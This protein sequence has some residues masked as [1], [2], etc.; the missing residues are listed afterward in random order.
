MVS[1]ATQTEEERET[2]QSSSCVPLGDK[3]V[4]VLN[5]TFRKLTDW[6]KDKCESETMQNTRIDVAVYRNNQHSAMANIN[7]IHTQ[8]D[9]G[10]GNPSEFPI[11]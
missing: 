7:W 11:Q 8:R 1:G 5:M 9:R 6:D 3:N 2:G 10:N 4:A